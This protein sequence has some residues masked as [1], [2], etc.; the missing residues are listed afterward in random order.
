MDFTFKDEQVEWSRLEMIAAMDKDTRAFVVN[1]RDGDSGGLIQ[2][3]V[4]VRRNS[5]DHQRCFASKARGDANS[6]KRQEHYD[7]AVTRKDGTGIRFHPNLTSSKFPMYDLEP[8]RHQVLNPI[9]GP[10]GTDGP[11]AYKYFKEVDME[12][13]GRFDS[14]R[15][16][17]QASREAGV[18]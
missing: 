13:E 15:G 6:G 12:R 11:G 4:S 10:G 17:E 18:S 7:F 1:G 9:G 2:C 5:Y 16:G 3:D 8:H 14:Q